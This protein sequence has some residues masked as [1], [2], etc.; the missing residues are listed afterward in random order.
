MP[1][2]LLRTIPSRIFG[3]RT[4]EEIIKQEYAQHKSNGII[5]RIFDLFNSWELNKMRNGDSVACGAS[6]ILVLKK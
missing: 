4:D 1:T 5:N 2:Y 6:C 3:K